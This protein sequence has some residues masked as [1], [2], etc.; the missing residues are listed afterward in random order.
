MDLEPW[1]AGFDHLALA[2]VARMEFYAKGQDL[3]LDVLNLPK[4]RDRPLS[5]SFFGAGP[6]QQL[7]KDLIQHRNLTSASHQG[8]SANIRDVWKRHHALILPSRQEGLPLSL[9][10]AALCGR[11]AIVTRIAG[12]TDV[13]REGKTGFVA[14]APVVSELDAAMER[15][16]QARAD[17][18][19][20]GMNARERILNE[21]PV[22]PVGHFVS[23]LETILRE[24]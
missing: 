6:N 20:M 17:L 10:E 23:E 21:F 1:P 19:R 14:A 7:L 2:C 24:A 18:P 5:V 8:V 11:P 12:N 15:A 22:D 13:T 3:I 9:V 16:W 4:W